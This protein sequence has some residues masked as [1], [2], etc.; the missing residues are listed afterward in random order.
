SIPSAAFFIFAGNG[1]AATNGGLPRVDV[2]Y[3]SSL[4]LVDTGFD[5]NLM[6][7]GTLVDAVSFSTAMPHGSSRELTSANLTA[8]DTDTEANG[9]TAATSYGAGGNGPPGAANDC[10]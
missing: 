8:T 6:A 2:N 5:M 10:P 4:T 3:G 7:A 1:S 9:C